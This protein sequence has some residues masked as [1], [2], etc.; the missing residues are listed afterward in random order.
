MVQCWTAT[1]LPGY[2]VAL[3]AA[4][5]D[6]LRLRTYAVVGLGFEQLV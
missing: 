4:Y 3:E 6:T 2:R 5:G 1:S